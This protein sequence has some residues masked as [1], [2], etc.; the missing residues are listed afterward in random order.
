MEGRDAREYVLIPRWIVHVMAIAVMVAI[1]GSVAVVWLNRIPILVEMGRALEIESPISSPDVVILSSLLRSDAGDRAAADALRIG[2]IAV[3]LLGKPFSPDDLVP[4]TESRRLP[5]LLAVG[6]PR[7]RIVEVYEGDDL[8][9][10]MAALAAVGRE[11]GWRRALMIS[12]PESSRRA[13]LV[14]QRILG[15]DGISVGQTLV[16][17][18]SPERADWWN[19][20]Q[21]R[22]HVVY[23][24]ILLAFARLAGRI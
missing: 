2:A 6:I 8:Y 5:R 18:D 3:V 11:A 9:E 17:P 20:D 10:T 4:A 19:D 14:A 15:E 16:A 23:N 24:W 1:V 22:G 7:E 12:A 21:L 13:F